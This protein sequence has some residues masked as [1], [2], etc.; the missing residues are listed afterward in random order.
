MKLGSL[1]FLFLFIH[2]VHFFCKQ[3]L[4]WKLQINQQFEETNAIKK[5][6]SGKQFIFLLICIKIVVLRMT[7]VFLLLLTKIMV[8]TQP[9]LQPSTNCL[10]QAPLYPTYTLIHS[11]PPLVT[12]LTLPSSC[13]A[14]IRN[15]LVE[16]GS[17]YLKIVSRAYLAKLGID[18]KNNRKPPMIPCKSLFVATFDGDNSNTILNDNNNLRILCIYNSDNL[19]S[20]SST[21]PWK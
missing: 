1:L 12:S 2:L 20:F 4:N 18:G 3:L 21:A 16:K 6:L 8:P 14:K 19:S 10:H 17:A 13:N 9:L 5:I 11:S 7:I 15:W